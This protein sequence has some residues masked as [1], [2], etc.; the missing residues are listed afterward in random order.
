MNERKDHKGDSFQTVFLIAALIVG[1]IAVYGLCCFVCWCVET[2]WQLYI[3]MGGVMGVIRLVTLVCGLALG[4]LA[5]VAC[6]KWASKLFSGLTWGLTVMNIS[7]I[8]VGSVDSLFHFFWLGVAL[9]CGCIILLPVLK[10]YLDN[11]QEDSKQN[12]EK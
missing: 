9:Y 10:R 8:F 3:Y 5:M 1:A 6:E 12:N 7:T 4:V 11:L 2:L